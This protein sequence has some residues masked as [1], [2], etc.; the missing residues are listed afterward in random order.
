VAIFQ[1]HEFIT[2]NGAIFSGVAI[3]AHIAILAQMPIFGHF[4][5]KKGLIFKTQPIAI[6][7]ISV[8]IFRW[9]T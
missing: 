9:Q 2:I 7:S 1:W 8:A 4:G 3:L 5:A 6:K